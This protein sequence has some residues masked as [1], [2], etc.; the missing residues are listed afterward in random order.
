VLIEMLYHAEQNPGLAASVALGLV[1]LIA[2]TTLVFTG[3]TRV[4]KKHLV[5]V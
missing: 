5:R 1:I 2:L 3:I 4:V